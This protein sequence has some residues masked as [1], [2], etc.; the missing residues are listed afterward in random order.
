MNKVTE[1]YGLPSAFTIIEELP[2]DKF[3][4]KQTLKRSIKDHYETSWLKDLSKLSSLFF[5]NPGTVRLGTPHPAWSTASYSTQ[6]VKQAISKVR[7][8]T[9]TFMNGQKA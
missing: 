4:W 7:L 5:L 2:W 3:S 9:D 1:I 8:L 6:A